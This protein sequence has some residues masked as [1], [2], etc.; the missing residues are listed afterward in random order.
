MC[1]NAK[2]PKRENFDL[3][4]FTLINPIW[5]GDLESEKKIVY[6]TIFTLIQSLFGEI[7]IWHMLSM[8]QKIFFAHTQHALQ[9]Q[10]GEYKHL[11]KIK[12]SLYSTQVA[13]ADTI[14][15]CKKARS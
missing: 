15:Y 13:Y 2:V 11:N 1:D 6:F 5:V 4:C 7:L 12:K 14:Y 9:R 8:R 10:S 3:A